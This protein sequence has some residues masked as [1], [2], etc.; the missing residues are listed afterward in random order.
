[1]KKINFFVKVN[2]LDAYCGDSN[3]TVNNQINCAIIYSTNEKNNKIETKFEEDNDFKVTEFS[4]MNY[5]L[6]FF[7]AILIT[8]HVFGS[9][10]F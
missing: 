1:M 7:I 10:W 3:R 4:S 5:F 9:F 2:N 6:L 8:R